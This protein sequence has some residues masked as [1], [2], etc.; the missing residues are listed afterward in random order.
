MYAMLFVL[1]LINTS[2]WPT[3]NQRTR[4]VPGTLIKYNNLWR[5]ITETAGGHTHTHTRVPDKK[6]LEKNATLL[7]NCN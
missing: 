7:F 4:R 1:A 3:G 6:N 2:I 5:L